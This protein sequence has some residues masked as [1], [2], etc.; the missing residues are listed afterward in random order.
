[1]TS[2]DLPAVARLREAARNHRLLAAAIRRGHPPRRADSRH[3]LVE[4][5]ADG[6]LLRVEVLGRELSGSRLARHV[7]ELYHAAT[8]PRVPAGEGVV[9]TELDRTIDAPHP[10]LGRRRFDIPAGVDPDAAPAELV[11]Q[12]TGRLRSRWEA[13]QRAAPRLA[14]LLGVGTALD[15]Q[16]VLRLAAGERLDSVTLSTWTR[17]LP[18]AELNDALQHD[19]GLARTDLRAQTG[20]VLDEAGIRP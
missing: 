11:Q 3:A 8:H 12:L 19:L 14:D 9:V 7:G 17:E 10:G 15:G 13:A 5:A 20:A 6:G 2:P 18:V 4:A 1:M 16:V